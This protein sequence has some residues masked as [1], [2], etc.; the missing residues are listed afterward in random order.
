TVTY[1]IVSAV[2]KAEEFI[3]DSK[4]FLPSNDIQR[5]FLAEFY[6]QSLSDISRMD[7]IESFAHTQATVI[8]KWLEERG[9]S[10][11]LGE[12]KKGS[13]GVVSMLDLLGEWLTK[14]Q[15]TSIIDDDKKQYPAV[16]ISGY[17]LKFYSIPGDKNL[18]VKLEIKN[19]DFVY[20]KMESE[21]P[22]GL[23]LPT[24]VETYHTK[25]QEYNAED[26]SGVIFPK[27]DLDIESKLD[28]LVGFGIENDNSE[29]PL[30]IIEEALQQTK[31]KMNSDGFRV[32]SAV[33]LGSAPISGMRKTEPYV[34]DKPFLMWVTRPQFARPL[35]VGYLNKDVW[36]DP[37][38]LEM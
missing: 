38:G 5:I 8:N 20:M 26:I 30:Y 12:F 10:I 35:F 34:I 37:E 4:G 19:G 1:P 2:M 9:F 14:G 27:I 18:V 11:R 3:Q 16:V 21:V 24:H 13:F 23:D 17:G 25:M 31:L 22:D 32:K 29:I 36:K 7:E 6:K 33:A 28:W 15:D